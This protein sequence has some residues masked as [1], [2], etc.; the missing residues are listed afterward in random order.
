MSRFSWIW[1]GV[2]NDPSA[3]ANAMW[4]ITY[5]SGAALLFS[6]I[7][8]EAERIWRIRARPWPERPVSEANKSG[9]HPLATR[10]SFAYSRSLLV[11]NKSGSEHR[12]PTVGAGFIV[13]LLIFS[14]VARRVHTTSK[15]QMLSMVKIRERCRSQSVGAR[16]VVPPLLLTSFAGLSYVAFS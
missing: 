14:S 2:E 10:N 11:M 4:A 16:S 9:E 7:P 13:G 1:T 8:L 5:V 15:C 12:P 6:L 3:R